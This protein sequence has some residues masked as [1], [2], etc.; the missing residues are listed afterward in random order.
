[1]SVE[2]YWQA[3]ARESFRDE[4]EHQ[5][6]K[7]TQVVAEQHDVRDVAAAINEWFDEQLAYI[8][9]WQHL[10]AELHCAKELDIAMFPV[11]I[12][13]LLDLTQASQQSAA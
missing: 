5:H 4:L 6:A 3:M 12:R 10:M 8:D 1:M 9:R 13:E 7:L 11:A 2:N